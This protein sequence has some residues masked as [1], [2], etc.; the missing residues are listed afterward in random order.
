MNTE[1]GENDHRYNPA[2]EEDIK[3][4]I[5]ERLENHVRQHEN[6]NNKLWLQRGHPLVR[7]FYMVEVGFPSHLNRVTGVEYYLSRFE[8]RISALY[9]YSISNGIVLGP[10]LR[11]RNTIAS[12]PVSL[13]S[14]VPLYALSKSFSGQ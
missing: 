13:D 6:Q 3:R 4:G 1:H 9:L 10:Y 12:H 5:V 8:I 14:K 11:E 7:A 2:E